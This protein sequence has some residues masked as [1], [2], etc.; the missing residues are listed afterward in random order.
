MA[1]YLI[2]ELVEVKDP[3]GLAEYRQKVEATLARYGGR[4][5]VAGGKVHPLEGDWQPRLAIIE[6]ESA[7]RAR[8][9]YDSPEYRPLRDLRQRSADVRLTLVEAA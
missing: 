1:A 2:G 6:F 7:E 8:A 5:R 9:F 4:F 3:A